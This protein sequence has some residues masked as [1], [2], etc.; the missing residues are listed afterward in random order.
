MDRTV[1]AAVMA[2]AIALGSVAGVGI[3]LG[4]DP[5]GALV[6]GGVVAGVAAWLLLAA[7][8]R[9]ETLHGPEHPQPSEPARGAGHTET[10][11]EDHRG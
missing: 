4:F 7:A 10:T 2:A 9:A 3:F 11:D 5:V 8:R 6:A 1:R